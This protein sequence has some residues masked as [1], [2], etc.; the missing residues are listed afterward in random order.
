MTQNARN[1][2]LASLQVDPRNKTAS[3]K[4]LDVLARAKF[5]EGLAQAP[6]GSIV[7]NQPATV[8]AGR[9]IPNLLG[10]V[11]L[12]LEADPNDPALVAQTAAW[13]DTSG[14]W[15][16]KTLEQGMASK[17]SRDPNLAEEAIAASLM[18]TAKAQSI[19]YQAG[20]MTA[21]NSSMMA[22]LAL[23]EYYPRAVIKL[24]F[25][26][27]FRKALDVARTLQNREELRREKPQFIEEQTVSRP[28]D[29]DSDEWLGIIDSLLANP[30]APLAKDFFS[31][32]QGLAEKWAK[33]PTKVFLEQLALGL[34]PTVGGVAEELGVTPGHVSNSN[35]EFFAFVAKNLSNPATRVP[36][37]LNLLSDARFL[38]DLLRG[39]VRGDRVASERIPAALARK[40]ARVAL[41]EYNEHLAA[42]LR[43]LAAR[44]PDLAPRIASIL[45]G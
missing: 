10:D 19:M 13:S 11:Y 16:V 23:G 8:L 21:N 41:R 37:V 40:A 3:I 12:G 18:G 22:K 42:N 2:I 25:P 31:W 20:R 38:S 43:R 45:A 5:L 27:V 7:K 24:I 14:A 32:L 1:R 35:S 29:L 4:A 17:F 36:E 28:S 15:W 39:R 34:D 44:R 33:E 9:V 30:D 26:M 6:E